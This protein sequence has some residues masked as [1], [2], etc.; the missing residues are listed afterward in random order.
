[1]STPQIT[2]HFG[3]RKKKTNR[4]TSKKLT[5][6]ADDSKFVKPSAELF[7]AIVPQLDQKT[8]DQKRLE[9]LNQSS[10]RKRN[11]EDENN[12][13]STDSRKSSIRYVVKN[14]NFGLQS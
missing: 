8:H 7:K 4:N 1:M 3:V 9:S 13:E 11:F 10:P 6:Q 2:D 14:N 12:P 5:L